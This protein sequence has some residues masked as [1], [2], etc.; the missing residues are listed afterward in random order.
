MTYKELNAVFAGKSFPLAAKN[1]D[2]ENIII[3]RGKGFF[4]LTTAQQNGWT[5][6]NMIFENGNADEFYELR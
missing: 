6:H 5:R 1:S 3:E 4:K 2:G